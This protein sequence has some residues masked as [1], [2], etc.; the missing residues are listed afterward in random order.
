MTHATSHAGR[1]PVPDAGAVP[2]AS[3]K[4]SPKEGGAT[5]PL[6]HRVYRALWR[7]TWLVFASWTPT[8]LHPWRR[9]LL[10]RFGA[11][12]SDTCDVHGSARVWFPPNLTLGERALLAHG[13]NCYNVAP[14]TLGDWAIVSQGAYLCT[15]SHDI[16]DPDFPM[17][18][19]PITIG[20]RAWVAADAFVGPGVTMGE[21]AVLAA[22]AVTVRDMDAWT[23]Y[24]GNPAS[25]RR[26]RR[27]PR[28]V[29]GGGQS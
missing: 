18:S 3:A 4:R 29:S 19:A 24:A 7:V 10:R 21:G 14:V 15:A 5:F 6:K 26:R 27:G 8:P 13:V 25:A 17:V 16:D 2:L 1:R 22:R 23:V 12:V 11:S 9:F 28:I 20:P